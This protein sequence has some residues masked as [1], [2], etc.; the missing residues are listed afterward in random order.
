MELPLV[1]GAH[2]AIKNFQKVEALRGYISLDHATVVALAFPSYEIALFHAVQ[3]TGNVRVARDHALADFATGQSV[4]ASAAKDT[5]YI[6]LGPGQAGGFDY[7]FGLSAEGVGDLHEGD[8]QA[9]LYTGAGAFMGQGTHGVNI[10]VITTV[11]KPRC[12]G[13][14]HIVTTKQ[15]SGVIEK[16]AARYEQRDQG[17]LKGRICRWLM[18]LLGLCVTIVSTA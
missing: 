9:G 18:K 14:R 4:A 2:R 16:I 12:A 13:E 1:Q 5:Q 8:E 10:V 6:V 3:K 15:P 7:L 17:L 11:V